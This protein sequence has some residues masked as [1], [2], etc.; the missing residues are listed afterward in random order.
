[1][2]TF[3]VTSVVPTNREERKHLVFPDVTVVYLPGPGDVEDCHTA[4]D[5]WHFD[6]STKRKFENKTAI[7]LG[8]PDWRYNTGSGVD[9]S[10]R[11]VPTANELCIQL[12]ANIKTIPAQATTVGHFEV[13]EVRTVVDSTEQVVHPSPLSWSADSRVDIVDGA[14]S[15]NVKIV[16][17]GEI[18]YLEGVREQKRLPFLKYEPDSASKS[19]FLRPVRNWDLQ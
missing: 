11:K 17:F 6:L 8:K 10:K 13:D 3:E 5:G 2:G 15:Q 14:T 4:P 9:W 1:M 16:L 19:V 7:Y 18:T 12:S